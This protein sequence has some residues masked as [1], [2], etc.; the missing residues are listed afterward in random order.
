VKPGAS[1]VKTAGFEE[2]KLLEGLQGPTVEMNRDDWDS[3]EREALDGLA[4]ETFSRDASACHVL[5]LETPD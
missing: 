3:I 2:V 5:V 4:G 1:R